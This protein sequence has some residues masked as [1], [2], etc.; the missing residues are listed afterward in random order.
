[1]SMMTLSKDGRKLLDAAIRP[2]DLILKVH[3]TVDVTL[4]HMLYSL[5]GRLT[6]TILAPIEGK[7]IYQNFLS[8]LT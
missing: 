5:Y 4:R 6:A 3:T 8:D 7:Q 1:M 2:S